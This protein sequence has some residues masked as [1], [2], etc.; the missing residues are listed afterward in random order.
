ME[1]GITIEVWAR[2]IINT[3]V[4]FFIFCSVFGTIVVAGAKLGIPYWV[5]YYKQKP[6]AHRGVAVS[7]LHIAALLLL[8]STLN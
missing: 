5:A 3:G 8:K 4:L 2:A 7:I 6:M 1:S